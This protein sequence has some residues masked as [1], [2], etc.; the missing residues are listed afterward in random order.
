MRSRWARGWVGVL[1]L[2][3]V[4]VSVH[5]IAPVRADDAVD[6]N[7]A[8]ARAAFAEGAADVEASKWGEALAAFEKS[9]TLRP[10]ALTTYNIGVCERALGRY[11]RARRALRDAVDRDAPS[12]GKE[13][14]ATYADQ[15]KTYLGEIDKLL[16]HLDVALAPADAKLLVDGRPLHVESKSPAIVV[17]GV[18]APGPETAP[19]SGTFE[20]LVDPGTHVILLSR[21]GYQSVAVHRTFAA[22]AH[23]ALPLTIDK[24]PAV[25]RIEAD[26]DDAIVTVNGL[27]VGTTP[28]VLQRPGGAYDVTVRAVGFV[29]Y[30]TSVDVLAGE[31]SRIRATLAAE[32]TPI[33]RRWWFWTIAGAVVAGAAISTWALTRP[34]PDRPQPDPGTLNWV[35]RTQ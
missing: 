25:L 8:A 32:S 1:A 21:T 11:T 10:H 7:T 14:P 18:A 12:G 9:A 16:V 15:A 29:T 5:P 4:A 13:L 19:P 31:E 28:V 35:A 27:D 22:G 6:A 34:T 20:L 26:R 23:A 3:V 33:T 30:H 2:S 24:L 17:G